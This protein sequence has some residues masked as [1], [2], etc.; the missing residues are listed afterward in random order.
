MKRLALLAGLALIGESFGLN[1]DVSVGVINHKPSGLIQHP[2]PNGDRIDAKRDLG[3]GDE[4]KVFGR[5]KLEHPLPLIPDV[6][7]QYM[8]M[9]FFGS[10]NINRRIRYG[11]VTYD[12]NVRLDSKVELD[13]FDVGLY[14][15]I[16]LFGLDPEIGVNTRIVS[17]KGSITGQEFLTN[18]V[19][20][21][22]KSATVPIPMLYGA[23]G[24]NLPAVPVSFRGEVRGISLSKASYY[25]WSL[26]GR[27][28]PTRTVPVYLSAG[29]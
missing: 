18:Q 23:L 16:P 21:E 12:V 10:G 22:S 2:V 19:R 6:Y 17:F 11:N 28:K 5:L 8:P 15:G 3:I 25:D 24:V 27:V 26:E 20:T 9:E 13:R 14:Y 29:Y 7:L 1:V 4:S